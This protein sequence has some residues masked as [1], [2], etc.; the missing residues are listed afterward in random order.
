MKYS[1]ISGQIDAETGSINDFIFSTWNP[2][3]AKDGNRGENNGPYVLG[4]PRRGDRENRAKARP[5]PPPGM[6]IAVECLLERERERETAKKCCRRLSPKLFV[7]NV[8][9]SIHI[10]KAEQSQSRSRGKLFLD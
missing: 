2:P 9:A 1:I 4:F 7:E 3:R 5:S 8:A 6:I 10:N